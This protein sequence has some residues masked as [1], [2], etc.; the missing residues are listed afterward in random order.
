MWL[1]LPNNQP[2]ILYSNNQPATSFSCFSILGAKAINVHVPSQC[3]SDQAI[4]R[5]SECRCVRLHV[6]QLVRYVRTTC[7]VF[8]GVGTW[9]AFFSPGSLPL[10]LPPP[11]LFPPSL[12]FPVLPLPPLPPISL[13][14]VCSY[15]YF[16]LLVDIA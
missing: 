6:F 1:L 2:G 16:P 12:S 9:E 4:G 15:S 11:S 10:Y 5:Y 14:L 13:P 3:A 7:T 8:L